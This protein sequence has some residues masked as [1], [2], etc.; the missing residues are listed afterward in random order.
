MAGMIDPRSTKLSDGGSGIAPAFELD[1]YERRHSGPSNPSTSDGVWYAPE[2]VVGY[3]R[4]ANVNCAR[5]FPF[6]E[7]CRFR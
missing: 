3:V 5:G 7:V 4:S 2:G 1:A 6:A